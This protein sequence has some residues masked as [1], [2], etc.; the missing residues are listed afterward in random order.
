MYD[1][2]QE[3]N[4]K[5]ADQF[6]QMRRMVCTFVIHKPRRQ[7]FSRRGPYSQTVGV[8]FTHSKMNLEKTLMPAFI[9]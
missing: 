5:G 2:S 4:N 3:V 1:T 6:A 9:M 7:G 8:F